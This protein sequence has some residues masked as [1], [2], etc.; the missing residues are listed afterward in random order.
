MQSQKRAS[1][2][3]LIIVLALLT[4]IGI[5]LGK[6]LAFNITEFMRFSLENLTIFLASIAF[7]PIA[8]LI[9]GVCEDIIG[10]MLAA[11]V[12]NPLITLGAALNGLVAGLVYRYAS[13]LPASLRIG[14]SVVAAHL[15]GS[16]LTKSAGLS[17]FYS[18]PFLPTL[19]WRVLNYAIVSAAEIVTLIYLLKSKV[20]LS[21]IDK[22]KQNFNK[23][24]V[25]A[26]DEL[27]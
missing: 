5:I 20:L 2:E 23:A 13:R 25:D 9:V 19:G 14:S 8:G 1:A 22:I 3:R 11:Y 18:L 26:D 17:I 12:W 24:K 15:V 16:V 6:F 10:C 21:N 7:G 27:H 4:A